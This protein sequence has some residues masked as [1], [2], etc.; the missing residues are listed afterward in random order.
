MRVFQQSFLEGFLGTARRRAH[1]AGKQANA[2]I[3]YGECGRLSARK[4]D[5]R[6]RDLLDLRASLEK[7]FVEPLET[8]ANQRHAGAAGNLAN[9]L[10]R[11]R[12]LAPRA[13]RAYR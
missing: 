4:D 7:P 11:D 10:L 3:K 2:S 9:T 1:Y 8:P 5:V 6:E 12:P 13:G